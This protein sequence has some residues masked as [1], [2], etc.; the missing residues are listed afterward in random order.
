MI[1]VMKSYFEIIVPLDVNADWLKGLREDLSD[2]GMRWQ[3]G[4]FHITVAFIKSSDNIDLIT[5][6]INNHLLTFQNV[7]RIKLNKLDAFPI[8]NGRTYITHLCA[9]EIPIEFSRW[10]KD[11]RNKLE[12]LNIDL[13]PDFKLHVTIGRISSEVIDLETLQYRLNK[14]EAPNI[15]LETKHFEYREFRGVTIKKWDF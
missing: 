13:E 5:S 14:H 4:F 10:I 9:T 1:K 6:I 8:S 7:F 12:D 3:N 15:D 2:V 11:L